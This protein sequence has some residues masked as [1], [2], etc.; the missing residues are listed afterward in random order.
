MLTAEFVKDGA[1]TEHLQAILPLCNLIVGTE[2]E[3]HIAGG[4]TD[5]LEAI[6][7]VRAVTGAAIVCKRGPMGC[8]VLK[9]L[10]ED[11]TTNERR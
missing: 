9:S 5:T 6:R 10:Q 7:A 8:V 1:V 4:A 11:E 2:E 3:L